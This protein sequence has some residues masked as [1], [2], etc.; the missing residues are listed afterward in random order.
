MVIGRIRIAAVIVNHGITLV[1]AI[2]ACINV[3]PAI[4][5]IVGGTRSYTRVAVEVLRPRVRRDGCTVGGEISSPVATFAAI[6]ANS[7]HT[8]YVSGG[9]L[10]VVLR[11]SGLGKARHHGPIAIRG[12]LLLKGVTIRSSILPGKGSTAGSDFG[13]LKRR[14][15]RT[16]WAAARS[17]GE[18]GLG[19]ERGLRY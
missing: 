9:R 17:I 12:F 3:V 19:D 13:I 6:S 4:W 15:L 5:Q 18:G 10:K 11:V 16:N 8:G 1:G 14:G 7:F 2:G